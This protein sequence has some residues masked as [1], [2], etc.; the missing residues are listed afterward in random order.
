ML[1]GFI[2]VV[3]WVLEKGEEH[4]LPFCIVAEYEGGVL[5][6]FGRYKKNLKKGINWKIPL[7]DYIISTYV[8]IDT[9]SLSNVNITTTDSRTITVGAAIEFD[10]Y[11]VKKYLID[12]NDARSN[13]IDISRGILADY[14]TDCKWHEIKDK[15]NLT[16]IKNKLKKETLNIGVDIKR[17]LI[18]D[19]ALTT[20]Y[21][22]IK[23]SE[24]IM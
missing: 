20:T 8:T 1:D 2:R 22:L 24:M 9:L 7:V 23:D 18:T 6:R 21:T 10:V 13:L 14:L 3:E 4:I 15:K 17:V 16:K 12:M 5:L 11:D 19:I